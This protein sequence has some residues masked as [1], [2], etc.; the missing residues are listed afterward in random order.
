[1]HSLRPLKGHLQGISKTLNGHISSETHFPKKMR[2]A[3]EIM[4][5]YFLGQKEH[6]EEVIPSLRPL[7][8]DLQGESKTLNGH[9]SSETHF[10]KKMSTA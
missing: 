6:F 3:W 5:S 1:M 2:T 9:I 10:P 4:L 8:R 7:K